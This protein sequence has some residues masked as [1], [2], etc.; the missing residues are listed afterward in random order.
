MTPWPRKPAAL[1]FATGVDRADVPS[2]DR[3]QVDARHLDRR[4]R[5]G[6]AP[7][8]PALFRLRTGTE[9]GRRERTRLTCAV[10]TIRPRVRRPT[11]S[12]QPASRSFAWRLSRRQSPR[13]T[14]S[15]RSSSL[16]A[17]PSIRRNGRF[18]M[19]LLALATAAATVI[20]DYVAYHAL[21][22]I[23]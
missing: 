18:G 23:T 10:I 8:L 11:V 4:T 17:N 22:G 3:G 21:T 6:P 16:P 13:V 20:A 15:S 2:A 14:Y 9:G 1:A 5:R 12:A 7:A 19:L